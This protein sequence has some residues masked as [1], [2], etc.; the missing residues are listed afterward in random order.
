MLLLLLTFHLFCLGFYVCHNIANIVGAISFDGVSTNALMVFFIIFEAAGCDGQCLILN[1]VL[2][3]LL[4]ANHVE[5]L[6]YSHMS[7]RKE[8]LR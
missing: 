2:D 1:E 8:H 4:H 6:D 3:W 5:W 7:A